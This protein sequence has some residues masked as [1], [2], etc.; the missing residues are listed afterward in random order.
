M[1]PRTFIKSD[2]KTGTT[3]M[4]IIMACAFVFSGAIVALS[5]LGYIS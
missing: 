5:R 4:V 2:Q 3:E 1:K